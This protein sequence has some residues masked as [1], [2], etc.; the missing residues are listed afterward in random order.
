MPIDNLVKQKKAIHTKDEQGQNLTEIDDDEDAE[1]KKAQRE[2]EKEAEKQ[3]QEIIE[4][5]EKERSRYILER[6]DWDKNFGDA[7]AGLMDDMHGGKPSMMS[8]LEESQEEKIQ[9]IRCG[10]IL[11]KQLTK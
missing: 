6:M 9:L 5:Q 11:W 7:G 3:L 1:G 2:E 8:E 10:R 4:I